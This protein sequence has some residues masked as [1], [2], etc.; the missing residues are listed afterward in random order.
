MLFIGQYEAVRLINSNELQ[1]GTGKIP[2]GA[3]ATIELSGPDAR[4]MNNP[5]YYQHSEES[6]R[7]ADVSST[8]VCAHAVAELGLQKF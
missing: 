2:I 3:S 8:L 5:A 6:K 4:A 1:L 7:L